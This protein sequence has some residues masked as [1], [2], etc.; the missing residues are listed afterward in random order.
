MLINP[1]LFSF[2]G[3][4]LHSILIY[5]YNINFVELDILINIDISCHC[6]NIF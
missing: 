3:L 6:K 2:I 5:M 1:I 4:P